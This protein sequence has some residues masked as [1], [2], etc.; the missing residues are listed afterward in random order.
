MRQ[1]LGVKIWEFGVFSHGHNFFSFWDTKVTKV[2]KRFY[3]YWTFRK[4]TSC[5]P[6]TQ[7]T[8]QK[9]Q[10]RLYAFQLAEFMK[11]QSRAFVYKAHLGWF[12]IGICIENQSNRSLSKF[13][14]DGFSN[15]RLEKNFFDIDFWWILAIW[16]VYFGPKIA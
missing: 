5:Y 2:W 9:Q 3:F 4:T 7:Q 8:Q 15:K 12:P 6:K 16:E 11:N 14:S 13:S 10:F 1:N